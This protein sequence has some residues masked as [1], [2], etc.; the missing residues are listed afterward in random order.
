MSTAA[1]HVRPQSAF[2]SAALHAGLILLLLLFAWWAQR[3]VEQPMEFELVAGEGDNYAATEAPTSAETASPPVALNVPVPKPLPPTPK[4]RPIER[5]PDPT[6]PK[7]VEKKPA[8]IKIEP[9]PVKPPVKVEPKPERVTYQAFTQ[10]HGKPVAKAPAPTKPVT[11]K[12]IDV[13]RVAAATTN[14]VTAGAGGK[15]MT[16]A[17][18]SLSQ[19]YVAMIIQRIRDAMEQ[20]GITDLREAGVQFSVS[21]T[22]VVSGARITQ[23][24]GNAAFDR[25]VLDAFSRVRPVGPPPTKRAE[26]FRTTIILSEG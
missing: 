4:P 10:E 1:L 18:T 24:S 25:A 14:V 20:A 8:D 12:S 9:A 26:V 22:G 3:E 17:E 21:A 6:P 15:A 2:L 23:S 7:V 19:R 5:Q 11:V 16:A 13:G